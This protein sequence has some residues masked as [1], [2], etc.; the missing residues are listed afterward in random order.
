[1]SVTVMGRVQLGTASF[2]CSAVYHSALNMLEDYFIQTT[3]NLLIGG[4]FF[5]QAA[6]YLFTVLTRNKNAWLEIINTLIKICLLHPP[7]FLNNVKNALRSSIQDLGGFRKAL[8]SK[9]EF[10]IENYVFH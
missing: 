7:D 5:T 6:S 4:M 10:N 1:M 9:I 2:T 8:I 3:I